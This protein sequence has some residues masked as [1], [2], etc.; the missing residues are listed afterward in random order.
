AA[1]SGTGDS[2]ADWM[3]GFPASGVRA[4]P[5]DTFGGD[6]TYSHFFVQDDVKINNRLTLNL[7]LRY[8]YSPWAKGYRGQIGTFDPTQ[9]KPIIVASETDQIDL[10]AQLAAP[11][12]YEFYK[13]LIQTSSQAGLPIQ[14]TATDTAQ[15]APRFGFAWRP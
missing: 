5:G 10:E 4:F 1:A 8:E 12:A 6:A 3:L 7:G 9:A 2:F 15:W 13:D 11:V 14:I